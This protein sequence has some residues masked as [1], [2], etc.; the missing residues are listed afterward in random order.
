MDPPPKFMS[1]PN[2]Y[3]DPVLKKYDAI[4]YVQL[5]SVRKVD[6]YLIWQLF[7]GFRPTPLY[8]SCQFDH[9]GIIQIRLF[10]LIPINGC[11]V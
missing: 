11:L 2:W 6:L 1:Q 10:D 5:E 4:D 8:Y 7:A 9:G 3:H